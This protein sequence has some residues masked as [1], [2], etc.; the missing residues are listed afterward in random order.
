MKVLFE[1]ALHSSPFEDEEAHDD[2]CK[3]AQPLSTSRRP[4]KRA[5]LDR[6]AV[7]NLVK[8]LSSRSL[9]CPSDDGEEKKEDI[10]HMTPIIEEF[11]TTKDGNEV[12]FEFS[13]ERAV[14]MESMKRAHRFLF[15]VIISMQNLSLNR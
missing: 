15:H 4:E 13:F 10:E 14:F 6:R 2:T 7:G 3:V 12:R 11:V 9:L 1:G 5:C 8:S